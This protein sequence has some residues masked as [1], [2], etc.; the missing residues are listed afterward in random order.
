MENKALKENHDR[1]IM[2]LTAVHEDAFK[3]EQC[4]RDEAKHTETTYQ[5]SVCVDNVSYSIINSN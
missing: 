2:D 5:V 4:A 1:I 3:Q